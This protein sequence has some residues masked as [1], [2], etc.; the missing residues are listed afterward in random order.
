MF[1][2]LY[3]SLVLITHKSNPFLI[4]YWVVFFILCFG[5][6]H[7]YRSIPESGSGS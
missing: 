1:T 5:R 7:V 6:I 3:L 2:D 4:E